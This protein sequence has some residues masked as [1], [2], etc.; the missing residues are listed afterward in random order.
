MA[1]RPLP[2]LSWRHPWAWLRRRLARDPSV[3]APEPD[4]GP[5]G[6][7]PWRRAALLPYHGAHWLEPPILALT[8][9]LLGW[10]SA[11]FWMALMG[12]WV[13]VRG[14]DRW[15]LRAARVADHPVPAA[16]R[17]AILVPVYNCARL[18]SRSRAP[19]RCR[20]STSTC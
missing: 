9:V 13:L 1:P 20:I 3:N 15:T 2:P 19:G 18:T 16:A 5:P 8:A 6:P 10:V 7:E 12:F 4:H 11:G 14:G 17:T